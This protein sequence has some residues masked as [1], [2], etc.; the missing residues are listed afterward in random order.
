[1][2]LLQATLK[3]EAEGMRSRLQKQGEMLVEEATV[4]KQRL[5]QVSDLTALLV[6]GE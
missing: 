4:E 6:A 2:D 1:V 3:A 5:Q